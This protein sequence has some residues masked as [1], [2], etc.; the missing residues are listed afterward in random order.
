MQ[1]FDQNIS[2]GT[3]VA[4]GD[5]PILHPARPNICQAEKQLDASDNNVLISH[6]C[7]ARTCELQFTCV[8]WLSNSFLT[9]LF[10]HNKN[11]SLTK[12]YAT[13]DVSYSIDFV[14][15]LRRLL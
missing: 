11:T 14:R 15:T 7:Y 5:H 2:G 12:D 13:N 4:R 10:T 6:H 1:Y 3:V 9:F 8:S